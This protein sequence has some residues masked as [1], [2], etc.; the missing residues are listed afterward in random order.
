MTAQLLLSS[1]TEK[2][3]SVLSNRKEGKTKPHNY[4]KIDLKMCT[5][6]SMLREIH[7]YI[8]CVFISSRRG[9]KPSTYCGHFV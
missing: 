7:T 9:E 3:T 1:L 4:H 6:I 2:V 8:N 5:E